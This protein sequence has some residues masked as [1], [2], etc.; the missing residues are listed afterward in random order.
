[1]DFEWNPGKQHVWRKGNMST[2]DKND[3]MRPEYDFSKGTRGKHHQSYR[4]GTN[5]VILDP[6]IAKVFKDSD[7]VNHALRMLMNLASNE[8]KRNKTKHPA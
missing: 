2:I 5:I 3:V 4:E 6:D 1:M 8:L 7:A